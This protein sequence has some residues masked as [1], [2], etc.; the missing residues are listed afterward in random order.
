MT[1]YIPVFFLS[2]FLFS[3]Q[4]AYV[5]KEVNFYALTG[6]LV[7]LSAVF[8][9]PSL[10]FKKPFQAVSKVNFTFLLFALYIAISVL[11]SPSPYVKYQK[12]FFW[13]LFTV[14]CFYLAQ[15][16]DFEKFTKSIFALVT[17]TVIGTCVQMHWTKNIAFVLGNNYL[18]AG[19]TFGLGIIVSLF[20]FSKSSIFPVI[21]GASLALM[22]F[23]GGGGALVSFTAALFF[24][25]FSQRGKLDL[26][27]KKL[28]LLSLSFEI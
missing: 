11:W 4:F 18:V 13:I 12:A 23:T 9:K 16:I 21:T 14:P 25:L 5:L 1:Q 7:F 22:L 27:K 2:S 28:L 8:L 20:Y 19:Q 17:L 15:K 24:F 6:F 26:S 10:L 3:F